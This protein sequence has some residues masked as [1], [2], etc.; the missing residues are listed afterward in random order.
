MYLS[1]SAGGEN[2]PKSTIYGCFFYKVNHA[3]ELMEDKIGHY[4][5][6]LRQPRSQQER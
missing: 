1:H 6:K 4:D 5:L 2:L 3:Q